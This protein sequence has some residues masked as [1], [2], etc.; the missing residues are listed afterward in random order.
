M[1]MVIVV[2]MDKLAFNIKIVIKSGPSHFFISG[3]I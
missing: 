3:Y 2:R 1:A